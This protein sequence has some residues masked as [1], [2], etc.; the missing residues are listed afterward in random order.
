MSSQPLANVHSMLNIDE[1]HATVEAN[2]A[3][4]IYI[5]RV[6][7]EREHSLLIARLHHLRRLLGYAPLQTGKEVRRAHVK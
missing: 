3:D 4:M 1:K 2:A 7:A 5:S 6:D